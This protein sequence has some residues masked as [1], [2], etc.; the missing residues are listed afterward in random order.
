MIRIPLLKDN[1]NHLFTYSALNNALDLFNE[2]TKAGA[3]KKIYNCNSNTLIIAKGWFDSYYNFE[4]NEFEDFPPI[5][6]ANNSLHSYF[7][8]TKAAELIE[9]DFPE[10]VENNQNQLWVEAN[11]NKIIAY[12][13]GLFAVTEES[14]KQTLESFKSQ[15]V[16][17]AS[18]MFVSNPEIFTFLGNSDLS[19][20][21]EV[22]TAPEIYRN[23]SDKEKK[24]CQGIK[25]FTDGALG[26]YSAAIESYKLKSN[27]FLTYTDKGLEEKIS[28][29]L[30]FK[31]QI[32]IHSIG[33]ISIS[34]VLKCVKNNINNISDSQIRIEHAQ[35]ITKEQA[36]LAKDMG[37]I[38]CMQPNFNMDSIVYA[39]RLS[40]KY[41]MA[42]NPFRMLIDEA[43]YIPEKDL[44]FGSDGMPTGIEGCLQQSLFPPT[45]GQKVSLDEFVAAY[46]TDNLKNGH[47]EVEIDQLKKKVIT[48]VYV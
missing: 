47:I 26:A 32:A 30:K 1:H 40:D 37:V 2:T 18:D 33:D 43:G 14:L 44:I 5:I 41:L 48:K 31:K 15:G 28:D 16:V 6:I 7:F 21:T 8:N 25:L 12:I 36:F 11:I 42:N 34:Q 20:F 35:F 19:Q 13:S 27:K 45:T 3:L 17:F 22:W 23:L 29:S 39:D 24:L 38:L 10:W 4:S 46:C 9:K